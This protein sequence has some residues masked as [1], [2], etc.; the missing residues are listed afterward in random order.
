[1]TVCIAAACSIRNEPA[2]I[3][4]HDWQGTVQAIGSS[5][6]VDKQRYLGN[7]WIALIAGEIAHADELTAVN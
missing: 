2:I 5:D 3:L 4:C 6:A 7:G 1:M